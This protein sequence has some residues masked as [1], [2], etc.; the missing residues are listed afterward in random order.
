M[1]D[2][3]YVPHP[4]TKKVA[5]KIP[6]PVQVKAEKHKKI[7]T[8]AVK[9]VKTTVTKRLSGNNV[10]MSDLPKFAQEKWRGTFLPTLYD[11]FFASDQPFDG[12]HKGSDHFI[13]L[14]QTIVKEVFP[15]INYKVTSSDSIHFLVCHFTSYII[16]SMLIVSL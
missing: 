15:D 14:L 3:D 12:F 7:K 1:T 4:A 8:A 13:T 16:P 6:H 2:E 11:K 9:S 5:T 10:R